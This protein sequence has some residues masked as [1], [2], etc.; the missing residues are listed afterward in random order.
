MFDVPIL[1]FDLETTGV[2]P[3]EDRIVQF[4]G[5]RTTPN[6]EPVEFTFNCNP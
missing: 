4:A 5:I 1:F 6:H 3:E 2:D